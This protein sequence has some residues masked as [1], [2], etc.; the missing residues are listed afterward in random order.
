MREVRM[1][2]GLL[3]AIVVGV[4]VAYDGPA[5]DEHRERRRA[6]RDRADARV[7]LDR[8]C[9]GCGRITCFADCHEPR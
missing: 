1:L 8:A 4:K 6:R 9:S 7:V 2:S 3:L 5:F